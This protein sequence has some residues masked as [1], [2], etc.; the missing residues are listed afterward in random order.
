MSALKA[1]DRPIKLGIITDLHQDIMHDGPARLKVFLD[2]MANEKP[3]ALLQLGD[4]AYPT[5]GNEVVTQGVPASRIH[6]PCMC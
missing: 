2:A 4:F 6:G 1:F 3:D 5:K